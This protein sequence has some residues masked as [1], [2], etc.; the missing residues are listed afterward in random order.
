[1][2]N[3]CLS[4]SKYPS[5]AW[6]SFSNTLRE[7]FSNTEH[8]FVFIYCQGHGFEIL[9]KPNAQCCKT[10]KNNPTLMPPTAN[11][12]V[13]GSFSTPTDIIKS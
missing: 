6:G 11:H 5:R 8:F 12:T 9:T 13:H 3:I 2:L 7:A 10:Q 1:M 4:M